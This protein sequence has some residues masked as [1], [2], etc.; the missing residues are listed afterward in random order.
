MG[1]LLDKIKSID[2]RILMGAGI[3]VAV[4]IIVIIVLAISGSKKIN[5]KNENSQKD[6]EIASE[7]FTENE[8]S[9][10]ILEE[11]TELETELS[12]EIQNTEDSGESGTVVNPN[13]QEILGGGNSSD[14]YVE[15]LSSNLTVTTV[16]VAPGAV[17]YYEI[18]NVGNM[19]L[20]I[21]DADAYVVTEDGKRHDAS[22]GKVGFTV[23]R[24]MSDETVSF[25]I[26]NK[27][28]TSKSFV[29]QF[30]NIKGTQMNPT[31]VDSILGGN[32][33]FSLNLSVGN[34]TGHYYKYIA[35][36]S[37]AI[38][39]YVSSFSSKTSGT[40]G[41]LS[42]TNNNT[43][44]QHTFLEDEVLTD[45]NGNKY[46]LMDVTAGDEIS[47]IVS[48][49]TVNNKYPAAEVTWLAEYQ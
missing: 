38:K 43:M 41:I 42:V 44:K 40:E 3:A 39:F 26:G 23:Q 29:L 28:T 11:T 49:K 2:K 12:T 31:K 47:I 37:G 15:R 16:S 30:S 45:E 17:V 32:N 5:S 24:A 4:I 25:Q 8:G 46:I 35:E 48:V 20:T 18:Y 36:Q 13:G 14:P 19:Y 7:F 22:N 34:N 6:S 10:E 21:S 27:G 9:T 33:A 1:K